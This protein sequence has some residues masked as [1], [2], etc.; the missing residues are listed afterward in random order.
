MVSSGVA[1]RSNRKN[2]FDLV[3]PTDFAPQTTSDHP[4]HQQDERKYPD[5]YPPEPIRRRPRHQRSLGGP[6]A[7]PDQRA[8]SRG[9]LLARHAVGDPGNPRRQQHRWRPVTDPGAG[10][11]TRTL[12]QRIHMPGL[13][14]PAG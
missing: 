5:D 12:P 11:T 7:G 1:L 14:N 6:A 10:R 3:G 8:V 2:Y 4:Q 9:V 13:G